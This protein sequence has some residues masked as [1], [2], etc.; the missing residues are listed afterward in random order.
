LRYVARKRNLNPIEAIIECI[1]ITKK[2]GS[3][4]EPTILNKINQEL[5]KLEREK[6]G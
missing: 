5:E 1:K 3:N 6:N 2:Y 4:G